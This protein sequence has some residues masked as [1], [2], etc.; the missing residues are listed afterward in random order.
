MGVPGKPA[1]GA[2]GKWSPIRI[3]RDNPS[4]RGDSR[5]QRYLARSLVAR[6]VH[7]CKQVSTTRALGM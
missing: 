4:G 7:G 3:A 5:L 1:R 6:S 2:N